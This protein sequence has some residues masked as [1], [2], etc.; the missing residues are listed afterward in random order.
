MSKRLL[1][2]RAILEKKPLPFIDSISMV[3]E[4]IFNWE[5]VIVGPADSPYA[6]GK[7]LLKLEFPTQYPFKAPNLRFATKVYHPSVKT[8]TGEVCTDV[9]GSWAPTLNAKHC[10]TVVYSM[11][12]SPQSDHPLEEAIAQ[13][14]AEKPK[15]FEKAAKKFTKTYAK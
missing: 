11:M 9:L 13:Q 8:D 1:K 7:F 3:Q 5:C 12:K 6:G 2:E 14:L 4:D 10:L 15:E